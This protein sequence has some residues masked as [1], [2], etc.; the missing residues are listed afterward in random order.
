MKIC[1]EC[2]QKEYETQED[3]YAPFPAFTIVGGLI[4]S[5][6]T[7]MTGLLS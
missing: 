3:K 6:A 1:K 7:L 5:A 4:G 2:M